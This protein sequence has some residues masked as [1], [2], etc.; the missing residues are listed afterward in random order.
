MRKKQLRSYIGCLVVA[1]YLLSTPSLAAADAPENICYDSQRLSRYRAVISGY[2]QEVK[3]AIAGGEGAKEYVALSLIRENWMPDEIPTK[4][5]RDCINRVAA[6]RQQYFPLPYDWSGFYPYG[7]LAQYDIIHSPLLLAQKIAASPY[8]HAGVY[9]KSVIAGIVA[10]LRSDNEALVGAFQEYLVEAERYY[11]SVL[12]VESNKKARPELF[13]IGKKGAAF[14]YELSRRVDAARIRRA[15]KQYEF[16]NLLYEAYAKYQNALAA[17]IAR[18]LQ[19]TQYGSGNAWYQERVYTDIKA[20]G[21]GVVSAT[22]TVSMHE[23]IWDGA[24]EVMEWHWVDYTTGPWTKQYSYGNWVG[25]EN[26]STL[27]AYLEK[28]YPSDTPRRSTIIDYGVKTYDYVN[29]IYAPA[30]AAREALKVDIQAVVNKYKTSFAFTGSVSLIPAKTYANPKPATYEPYVSASAELPGIVR[31]TPAPVEHISGLSVS[32]ADNK[33]EK[34]WYEL[35]F[36]LSSRVSALFNGVSAVYDGANPGPLRYRW[37]LTAIPETQEARCLSYAPYQVISTAPNL[38]FKPPQSQDVSGPYKVK[39]DVS[40]GTQLVES[41]EFTLTPR[42]YA[43]QLRH[44]DENIILENDPTGNHLLEVS[45]DEAGIYANFADNGIAVD[46]LAAAPEL[47]AGQF[48][49]RQSFSM[50]LVEG[51]TGCYDGRGGSTDFYT[52]ARLFTFQYSEPAFYSWVSPVRLASASLTPGWAKIRI[53]AQSKL[54]THLAVSSNREQLIIARSSASQ[55]PVATYSIRQWVD[56]DIW[57]NP[58]GK[59][60]KKAKRAAGQAAC[61]D[62]MEERAATTIN[63]DPLLVKFTGRIE[64]THDP[65]FFGLAYGGTDLIKLNPDFWVMRW[66]QGSGN[67]YGFWTDHRLDG[68]ARHEAHH[69]LFY[70][71]RDK[72]LATDADKDGLFVESVNGMFEY[73]QDTV[74]NP[75][76][77]C[78]YRHYEPFMYQVTYYADKQWEIEKDTKR[79]AAVFPFDVVSRTPAD[80][81]IPLN[82]KIPVRKVSVQA[83][84]GSSSSG[85]V[86]LKQDY[87]FTVELANRYTMAPR[88]IVHI[89]NPQVWTADFTGKSIANQIKIVYDLHAAYPLMELEASRIEPGEYTGRWNDK[90]QK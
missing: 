32:L 13:E 3:A 6:L 17:G 53:E 68:V 85:Y 34:L 89:I 11:S 47:F 90:A 33:Y 74:D 84:I 9:S 43:L 63:Q 40:N 21:W 1:A 16:D 87:H 26:V 27:R 50:E 67:G 49:S 51:G 81:S 22:E 71:Y 72:G 58:D 25:L 44:H 59:G 2:L 65:Q 73:L 29:G 41:Q 46:R 75:H 15:Q 37:I 61:V 57:L 10:K 78:G 79:I 18:A 64:E 5:A 82:Q 62:W 80:I 60:F 31:E 48:S 7:Y 56:N 45:Y 12:L 55:A 70:N 4:T 83:G 28:L 42:R 77:G 38:D 54:L 52:G 20:V 19:K 14:A 36:R 24:L 66:N 30:L 86:M 35:P 8:Y 39:L 69:I 23:W 76:G 88:F